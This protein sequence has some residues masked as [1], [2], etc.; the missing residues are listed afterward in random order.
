[1]GLHDSTTNTANT[2]HDETNKTSYE[3]STPDPASM[4]DC[5]HAEGEAYAPICWDCAE[6]GHVESYGVSPAS[7]SIRMLKRK[8]ARRNENSSY[9]GSTVGSRGSQSLFPEW[10]P[11]EQGL[12][13]R[14]IGGFPAPGNQV[15]FLEFL[16][17][18]WLTS[19]IYFSAG[20]VLSFTA[21]DE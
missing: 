19:F 7:D 14:Y 3:Y 18:L 13:M 8:L 17:S 6:E 11:P 21:F 16:L 2:I 1:M 10:H 12:E 4:P 5:P 9:G 15:S 20:R